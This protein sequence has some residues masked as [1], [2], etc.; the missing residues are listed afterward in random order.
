M[1]RLLSKESNIFS[2]PLYLA[3][4]FLAL[5]SMS[6]QDI[7]VYAVTSASLAMIG[8]GLGF[9]CFHTLGIT[10]FNHLPYVLYLLFVVTFYPD[11]LALGT[12]IAVLANSI[13]IYSLSGMRERPDSALYL[14]LGNVSASA[15]LALPTTWP[16][17]IFLL[18]HIISTSS[19]IIKNII[20][21]LFGI[22]LTC[23]FYLGFA[24]VLGA[25]SWSSKYWPF[26]GWHWVDTWKNYVILLPIVLFTLYSIANHFFH[27]NQKSPI[28]RFRYTFLLLFLLAQLVTIFMYMGK[29]YEYLLLIAL[30]VSIIIAR[31]L[32][33]LPKY[34]MRELLLWIIILSALA[35]KLG[36]YLPEAVPLHL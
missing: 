18:I 25:D 9:F 26:H 29:S 36:I 35:F 5:V 3:L 15:F 7:S 4:L 12:A 30:P 34:W 19:S 21:Y 2:V 6:V 31:G 16:M 23:L 22:I 8:F 20:R 24:Y 33:F 1:F 32:R 10:Y 28:S 17:G 14:V 27:Y 13:V 11:T